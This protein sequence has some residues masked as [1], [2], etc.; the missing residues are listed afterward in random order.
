MTASHPVGQLSDV[1]SSACALLGVPGTADRL[2]L[3]GRVG[4]VDR[5]VVLL[6]DGLGYHLLPAAAPHAPTLSA[7]L[8]GRFGTL[9]ELTCTFPSTTPTSLVTLGTGVGP[10]EHGILGFTLNVPGTDRV[11]T[12]ITWTGDPP[13][14]IWQPVPTLLARAEQAGVRVSLVSRPEYQGSGL[15]EA[16]YGTPHYVGAARG[17]ELAEQIVTEIGS[18]PGLV[19]GYHPTLDTVAHLKGIASPDWARA[20]HDVDRLITRIAE[21]LPSGAALLVTADHGALDVPAASRTDLDADPRLAAGVRVVAGEPRVRYLH[22]APGAEADVL[23]A[24]QAVLGDRAD[25]LSR[26]E[27]VDSGL[28]GAVRNEHLARIGDVVVI[29]RGD[30]VVL[31]SGHE[32]DMVSKLVAFHGSLTPVETAIPL[33]TVV[34][35]VKR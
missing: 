33:L 19:Y 8:D 3:A 29:C 25:V 1:L 20:A 34:G 16:A 24:W 7:A 32:P 17:E 10:G 13:V 21:G 12:H 30:T 28:F 9:D 6:V 31:A 11:L 23:A 5:I 22:T 27:A 18:G 2:S 14:P 4:E 26:E 35:G 15:T